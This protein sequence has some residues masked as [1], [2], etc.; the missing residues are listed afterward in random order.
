MKA[1]KIIKVLIIIFFSNSN[2]VSILKYLSY[3]NI[4]IIRVL[5]IKLLY[6]KIFWWIKN[7]NIHSVIVNVAKNKYFIYHLNIIPVTYFLIIY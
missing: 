6:N 5:L 2:L 1:S 4:K 3:K 7:L